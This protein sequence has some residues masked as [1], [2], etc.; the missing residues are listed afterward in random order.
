MAGR[1]GPALPPPA[2][3]FFTWVLDGQAG[4]VSSSLHPVSQRL[5][6]HLCARMGV[7]VTLTESSHQAPRS[8]GMQ[9]LDQKASSC[10]TAKTLAREQ[11][12]CLKRS[13]KDDV[14]SASGV[15]CTEARGFLSASTRDRFG[16]STWLQAVLLR[17]GDAGVQ[18]MWVPNGSKGRLGLTCV[19]HS[20]S[21]S[22]W[23]LW[24]LPQVPISSPVIWGD[25]A[26]TLCGVWKLPIRL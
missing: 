9:F 6:R 21:V 25:T 13:V 26:P 11:R 1:Q 23:A 24:S 5:V 16:V 4:A 7:P 3:L 20:H 15:A 17:G 19:H 14:T 8:T 12:L 18:P 2:S 22:P 10:L